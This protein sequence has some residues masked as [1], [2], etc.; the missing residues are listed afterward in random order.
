MSAAYHRQ[1]LESLPSP[2]L[3]SP[4]GRINLPHGFLIRSNGDHRC[5]AHLLSCYGETEVGKIKS[6]TCLFCPDIAIQYTFLRVYATDGM[7]GRLL[8]PLKSLSRSLPKTPLDLC[9]REGQLELCETLCSVCTSGEKG[10][11]PIGQLSDPPNEKNPCG[12]TSH[13]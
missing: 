8:S 12:V 5:P 7:C 2:E 9:P 6:S 4:A 1:I 11:V 13:D 10:S 3:R